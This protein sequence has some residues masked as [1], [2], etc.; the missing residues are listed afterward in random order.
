MKN[1]RDLY[2]ELLVALDDG[3]YA[4]AE[5]LGIEAYLENFEYLEP[6]IEKVNAEH[7]YALELDMREELRKMIKFKESPAAIRAFLRR[8]NFT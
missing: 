5:E 6:D 1:I 7:L 8:I 3:D 4:L 2:K